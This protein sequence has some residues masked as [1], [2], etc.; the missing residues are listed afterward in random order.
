MMTNIENLMS[1]MDDLKFDNLNDDELK[2]YEQTETTINQPK[3]DFPDDDSN[4]GGN[5]VEP[6]ENDSDETTISIG[7]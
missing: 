7:H 4:I 2:D 5:P 6:D 3:F 1:W